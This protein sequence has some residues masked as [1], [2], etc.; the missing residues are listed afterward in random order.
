MQPSASQA[1]VLDDVEDLRRFIARP[2]TTWRLRLT[3]DHVDVE[4]GVDE[5]GV[6]G[7]SHGAIS[8]ALRGQN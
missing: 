2:I 6:N 5:V 3:D 8:F 4:I 1:E 7:A